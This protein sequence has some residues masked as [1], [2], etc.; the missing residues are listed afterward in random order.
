M[1]FQTVVNN[2]PAPGEAGDFYGVNP[3][4]SVIGGPGM[5][6][7]P[8]DGL[9]VGNFCW[10]N[11]A[12]GEVSQSYLP[13][14]IIGFLHRENNAVITE[15]LGEAVYV[16]YRG[17]PVTLFDQGDFWARFAD[18]ATPG[19]AV[20]ADA[21]TGTPI[22]G[23]TAPT[24]DT[25]TGSAGFTGTAQMGAT[26]TTIAITANVATLVVATGYVTVGDIVTSAN[27]AGLPIGAQLTG[28]A[29]GSGTYTFV[30]A[31]VAA[32]AGTVA[33]NLL[34]VTATVRGALVIGSVVTGGAMAVNSTVTAIPGGGFYTISGAPQT[35]ASGTKN[36]NTDTLAVTILTTG[37]IAPGDVIAGAGVTAGTQVLEQLTGTP[38][39]VGTY[40]ISVSQNF[41][42]TALTVGAIATPWFVDSLAADGELAK[43]STWG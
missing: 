19:Q 7:A 14:G 36:A 28:P 26:L 1:G 9:I 25:F 42:S 16:V 27:I 39:G 35:V 37:D 15:F 40:R 8:E 5:Y 12:T 20:F 18:G 43:I 6:R 21:G 33:S 23:D 24:T 2:Q 13:G 10:V 38:G 29:G 30:H 17:L 4:A 32:E 22:A 31:D 11:P 3:R 34:H 41:A